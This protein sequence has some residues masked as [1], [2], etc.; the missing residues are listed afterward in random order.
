MTTLRDLF[1]S[2]YICADD[3]KGRDHTLT[4]QEIVKEEVYDKKE[5]KHVLKPALYFKDKKKGLILNI[6]CAR[7]V[8][9]LYGK[10]IEDWIGKRITI[11]PTTEYNFG[12]EQDVVRVRATVPPSPPAPTPGMGAVTAP[13][14]EPTTQPEPESQS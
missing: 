7:I 1:P 8:Q 14:A 5:R 12:E 3:L 4:I 11:Y 10:Q 2:N 9:K 13:Q 6:T